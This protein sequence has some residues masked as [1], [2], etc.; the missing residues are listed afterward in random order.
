MEVGQV[1]E[2][3]RMTAT[4]LSLTNDGRPARVAFR[5]E[6]PLEDDVP[7]LASFSQGRLRAMEAA[8]PW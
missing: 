4:V 3:A 5:F 8:T 7:S 6:T 2:I 1:V